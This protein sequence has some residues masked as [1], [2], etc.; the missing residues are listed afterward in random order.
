VTYWVME[1]Q[2]P[3]SDCV[4]EVSIGGDICARVYFANEHG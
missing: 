1:R 3:L 2:R 4:P